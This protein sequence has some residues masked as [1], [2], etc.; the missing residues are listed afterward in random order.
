M[1]CRPL[2]QGRTAVFGHIVTD[3]LEALYF[4]PVSFKVRSAVGLPQGLRRVP[5][6]QHDAETY[7]R[8]GHSEHEA[9]IYLVGIHICV[10]SFVCTECGATTRQTTE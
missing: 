4:S 7:D 6:R 9:K 1:T 8:T 5:R 3:E 10:C 2:C